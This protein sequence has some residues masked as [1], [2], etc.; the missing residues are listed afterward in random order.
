MRKIYHLIQHERNKAAAR[1][2]KAFKRYRMFN[3]IPK[4]LKFRKNIMVLRI[5]KF[6]RGYKVYSKINKIIR[7]KHMKE[8]FEYF[9]SLR[10]EVVYGIL[11][12][13]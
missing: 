2:Q 1:I 13:N 4:A 9:E 6:L 7:D 5:Q 3:L 8:T 12:I 11:T 10:K